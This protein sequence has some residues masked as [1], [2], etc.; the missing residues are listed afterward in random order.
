MIGTRDVNVILD[1]L[2]LYMLCCFR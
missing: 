2:R 1:G